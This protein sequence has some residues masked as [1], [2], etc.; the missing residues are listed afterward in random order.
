[1]NDEASPTICVC[2]EGGRGYHIISRA[3]YD[4]DPDA[5]KVF[6]PEDTPPTV[7]PVAATF[8]HD[9]IFDDM[10]DAELRAYIEGRPGG[11]RPHHKLKRENLLTKAREA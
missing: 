1:M 11:V 5:Y 2:R 10:S 8:D 3:K 7:F 6:E 4:A 9:R